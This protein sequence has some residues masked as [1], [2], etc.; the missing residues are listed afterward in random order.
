MRPMINLTTQWQSSNQ[1][2][3]PDE[4]LNSHHC[5]L[6]IGKEGTYH[7]ICSNKLNK[8]M[9]PTANNNFNKTEI[10]K[11]LLKGRFTAVLHNIIKYTYGNS[12]LFCRFILALLDQ[13]VWSARPKKKSASLEVAM[14]FHDFIWKIKNK[15]D[16]K[17]INTI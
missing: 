16:G 14:D 4:H 1:R 17:A 9:E 13:Q 12:P 11:C 7:S 5:R 15:N 10:C 2:G 6:P 8:Y 3:K